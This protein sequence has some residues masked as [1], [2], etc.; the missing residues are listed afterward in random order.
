MV[1]GENKP[2]IACRNKLVSSTKFLSKKPENTRRNVEGVTQSITDY[3]EAERSKA[4]TQVFIYVLAASKDPEEI[5]CQVPWCVDEDLIFFGPCKKR[6]RELLRKNYLLPDKSH[7]NVDEDIFIVGV[8]GSNRM[9][10]RKVVWAG[11]LSEVMTFAEAY[12]R[13]QGSR[14]LKLRN[15]LSS[16]LHVKPVSLNGKFIGYEHVSNEHI[17][18]DSWVLDL[19][20]N[21][22]NHN[23]LLE[24]RRLILQ[25]EK[26][27][28]VF[29]RDCCMF[30]ENRFFAAGHGLE[31]DE[32]ALEILRNAQPGKLGINHYAIFGR[33][34]KGKGNAEGLLGR[35]LQI[36][37]DLANGFVTWIE[38]RSLEAVTRKGGERNGFAETHCH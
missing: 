31:F 25:P 13:M 24:G 9:K 28:Q 29:D 34:K 10:I 27:E 8:N 36:S 5:H 16:P 32:V 35:Y 37:G 18:K 38:N 15:H 3:S 4:M 23:V 12:K 22:T 26:T 20:S 17:E 21:R 11:R 6:I 33:Q 19:V 1:N 30:L 7:S 14:Y 2:H